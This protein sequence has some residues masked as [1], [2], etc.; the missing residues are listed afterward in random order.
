ML[1][2]D[3]EPVPPWLIWIV[4]TAPVAIVAVVVSI[5]YR[6]AAVTNRILNESLERDKARFAF[7]TDQTEEMLK[8]LQN[9]LDRMEKKLKEAEKTK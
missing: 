8:R 1:L 2:A 6:F 7:F 4:V 3:G 5:L 9:E